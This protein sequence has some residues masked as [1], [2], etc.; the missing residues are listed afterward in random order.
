MELLGARLVER[1]DIELQHAVE[2]ILLRAR[3]GNIPELDFSDIIGELN[4]TRP[5][6]YI[7]PND[8]EFKQTLIDVLQQ[9]DWVQHADPSGTVTMKKP[10]EVTPGSEEPGA[11]VK[12]AQDRQHDKAQKTAMSN[13]KSGEL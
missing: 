5:E 6:M 13:V 11:E 2:D 3:K 12:Q 10:G 4:K 7:N 1:G 9:S 8:E